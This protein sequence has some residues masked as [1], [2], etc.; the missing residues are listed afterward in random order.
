[1]RDGFR[2][3]GLSCLVLAVLFAAFACDEQ[4]SAENLP[5]QAL[6][7]PVGIAVHPQGFALVVNSN[8]NLRYKSGSLQ[9]IDLNLLADMIDHGED[10]SCT[11]P[12]NSCP[13]IADQ[14]IGLPNFG[15]SIK[16]VSSDENGLAVLATRENNEVFFVDMQ[17]GIDENNK[18]TVKLNCRPTADQSTDSYPPCEG[19][20]YVLDLDDDD[21]FD[22]ILIDDS[23]A[24]AT[25]WEQRQ[26]KAYVSYL[27][28]GNIS[29]VE[30]PPRLSGSPDNPRLIYSLDAGARGSSN[31]TYSPTSGLIYISTRFNDS[32]SNPIR[33]FNPSAGEDA[34]IFF[35]DLYSRILGYETRGIDFAPD[36]R[37]MGI[38][39]R[40]PDM[41]LFVDTTLSETGL[42][43]DTILGEV[44][45]SDNPSKVRFI[46]DL[47]LVT[48]A[49]DDTFFVIDALTMKMIA[50]KEDVCRGPYDVDV[51]DRGDLRWALVTCFEDDVVAVVDVDPQSETFLDV[52]ARVGKLRVGDE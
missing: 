48:S 25:Q 31:M 5:K 27:R 11:D 38:V 40:N 16:L 13:I 47:A 43:S 8:F 51:Y 32:R 28:S 21:P 19:A 14:A 12:D 20:G 18:S 26:W 22:M 1:V 9:V 23:P 29:A 50:I 30:I 36:G 34:E 49:E 39:V 35:V 44:V 41:L 3:I 24:D 15:S 6:R 7:F 10:T 42:P 37:T 52:L 33:Y 45:L 2:N 4:R 46:G 17:I